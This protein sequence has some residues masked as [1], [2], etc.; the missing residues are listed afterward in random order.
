[1]YDQPVGPTAP[2]TISL[3]SMEFLET[4]WLQIFQLF[5]IPFF[6]LLLWLVIGWVLNGFK[7]G[8]GV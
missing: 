5:F 6:V 3:F 8:E 4:I 2:G 7:D 1:M